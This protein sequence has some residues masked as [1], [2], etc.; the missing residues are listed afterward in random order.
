MVQVEAEQVRTGMMSAQTDGKVKRMQ[1]FLSFISEHNFSRGYPPTVRE[2]G[3]AL[4][5]SSTSGPSYRLAAARVAGL[6]TYQDT[7]PRT[8]RLTDKGER[9]LVGAEKIRDG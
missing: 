6:V 9:F 1:D 8:V 7:L 4:G 2:I 3:R 5:M